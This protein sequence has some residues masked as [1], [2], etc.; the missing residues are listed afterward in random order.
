[1]NLENIIL[2]KTNQTQNGKSHGLMYVGPKNVELRDVE[3]RM[4]VTRG[5]GWWE[6]VGQMIQHFI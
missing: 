1:M 5:K 6:D 4:I 2:S 3:S